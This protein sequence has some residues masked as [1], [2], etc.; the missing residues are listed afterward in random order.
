MA[1]KL[2]LRM[3]PGVPMA[4]HM[5]LSMR[6]LSTC[7]ATRVP[8]TFASKPSPL[9]PRSL[10]QQ[11]FRRGYANA[12]EVKLSPDPKPR[13]RFRFFRWIWRLTYLSA[14]AGVGYVSYQVYD[15]RH[16]MEQSEPDPSKK[17]L[18]ILGLSAVV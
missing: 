10:L 13:K 7:R 4:S 9:L 1:S 5:P 12:P 6:A 11:S 15:L 16:P 17:T 14:L 18:V 8:V 3:V 2:P